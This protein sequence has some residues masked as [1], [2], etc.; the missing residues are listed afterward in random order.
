MRGIILAGQ[1][2]KGDGY[3]LGAKQ[4]FTL[5]EL[6]NM[7]GIGYKMVDERKGDRKTAV[8]DLTLTEKDLGW[9]AQVKLKDHIK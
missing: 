8:I 3:P 9:S 2:G 4:T 7:F 6:A 1:K 5:F